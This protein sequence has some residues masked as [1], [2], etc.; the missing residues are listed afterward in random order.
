[1]LP[2]RRTHKFPIFLFS[3]KNE[4]EEKHK[5]FKRNKQFSVVIHCLHVRYSVPLYYLYTPYHPYHH[6]PA[7]T[8]S[9]MLFAVCTVHLLLSEQ[10][11]IKYIHMK[12]TQKQCILTNLYYFDF[13]IWNW[14]NYGTGSN[15]FDILEWTSLV[16]L[17]LSSTS[18]NISQ[19]L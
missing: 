6:R 1:M 17:L 3:H 9:C 16:E 14:F 8:R 13:I 12:T 19:Y 5:S 15:R 11:A 7:F 2:R 18:A 4:Q 10:C